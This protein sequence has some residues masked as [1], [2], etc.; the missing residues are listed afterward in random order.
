MVWGDHPLR[1]FGLED[2]GGR[3]KDEVKRSAWC[4]VREERRGN[5][6]CYL[7]RIEAKARYNSC[8]GGEND[9]C[10]HRFSSHTIRFE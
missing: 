10:R 3:M 5:L 8:G 9:L 4:V 2:E 6:A 1:L 7:N